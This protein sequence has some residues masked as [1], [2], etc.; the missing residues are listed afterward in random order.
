M[1]SVLYRWTRRK[2]DR[3][4]DHG[5]LG[6]DDPVELLDGLLLVKEPQ[7]SLHATA[8]VLVATALERVFRN[9][10]FIQRYGPIAVGAR[11]EP[12]PDVAVIR[13]VPRDYAHAHPTSAALVV[14]VAR[15]GLRA[16]RGR[17][18]AVYART[19]IAD[20][21]IVNL[22]DRVLEVQREPARPGPARSRWGYA[23]IETLG[24]EA[25]EAPLAAPDARVRVADLLP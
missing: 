23:S 1:K 19:H 12:E 21:W 17:K 8:V 6:K 15:S 14:E 24:A 18:A 5:I 25:T 11:S 10:W 16:A 7:H 2:Y 9:G 13:G 20:Y 4:V 22:V 3:L